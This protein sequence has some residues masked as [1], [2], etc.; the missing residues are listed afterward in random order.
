MVF[1]H[2]QRQGG[3]CNQTKIVENRPLTIATSQ[4]VVI[5]ICLKSTLKHF[6]IQTSSILEY[7]D[8]KKAQLGSNLGFTTFRSPDFFIFSS[9][10]LA[11]LLGSVPI[12]RAILAAGPSSLSSLTA[13]ELLF[14]LESLSLS[15]L[16][17]DLKSKFGCTSKY[18]LFEKF[19]YKQYKCNQ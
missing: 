4:H 9:R 7:I 8:D 17:L 13:L 18:I 12:A 19:G 3:E 16:E 15:F 5:S 11:S 10:N 14:L 1:P 6:T 2:D